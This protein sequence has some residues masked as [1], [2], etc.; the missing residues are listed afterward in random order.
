MSDPII[1]NFT[2]GDIPQVMAL[3]K[4][5]QQLY[6][7]AKVIPGEVYLSPGF[8]DGKNI[9]CALD[10]KGL[11]QGYAPL[12]PALIENPQI[13]NTLWAEARVDPR[14]PSARE[15]KDGLFERLSARAREIAQASPGHSAQLIFQYHP[16]EIFSIEYAISRGCTYSESVFRLVRDLSQDLPVVTAPEWIKIRRWRMESEEEQQAYVQA[17]NEA[18]PE[19]PVTLADWQSFLHSPA[20]EEGTTIT[21]FDQQ[22]IAGSVTVYWD[23]AISQQ[24]RRKVGFT[25]YIFV[26]PGWRK[27]GIAPCM[28]AQGLVY[29]KEHGREAAVLE[30]K[31]ANQRALDLYVG[32]E[33]QL[34]DETRLY[35]LKL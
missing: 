8:G 29:L 28:I 3:Q 11:L 4:A 33:Y 1:R 27:R 10:E 21:A 12:F 13:P 19:A 20:W 24:V 14:L 34:V 35:V 15:I 7:N 22:E 30:V 5:Y 26:R 32:L 18:F 16:S 23:E 9:F 31:A 6:P 25:E 17:H 2:P